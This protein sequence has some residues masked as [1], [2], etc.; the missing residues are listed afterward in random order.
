MET[1]SHTCPPLRVECGAVKHNSSPFTETTCASNSNV[2][3]SCLKISSAISIACCMSAPSAPSD[4]YRVLRISRISI[5]Q[6][7]YILIDSGTREIQMSLEDYDE[8]DKRIIETLCRSSQ[9]STGRCQTLNVHRPPLSRG[10]RTSS[11]R[12]IQGIVPVSTI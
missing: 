10:S 9:G 4:K 8:L 2:Y 7:L 1:V 11:P 6:P 3:P 12:V 5:D